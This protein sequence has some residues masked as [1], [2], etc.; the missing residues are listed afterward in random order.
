MLDMAISPSFKVGSI[1]PL[2]QLTARRFVEV[3]NC[4]TAALLLSA[5]LGWMNARPTPQFET[6]NPDI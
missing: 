5:L 2:A 6:Y 4:H 1:E 3:K